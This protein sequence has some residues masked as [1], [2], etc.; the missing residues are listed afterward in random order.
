[1]EPTNKAPY[2]PRFEFG[3]DTDPSDTLTGKLADLLDELNFERDSN[4]SGKRL[5]QTDPDGD[6]LNTK[7]LQRTLKFVRQ[8]TG[9]SFSGTKKALPLSTLKTIKLLYNSN[10]SSDRHLFNF[11][12]PPKNGR[13][14]MEFSTGS[15]IA[16]DKTGAAIIRSLSDRLAREIDQQKIESFNALFPNAEDLQRHIEKV[17]DVDCCRFR[18]HHPKLIASVARTAWG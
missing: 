3:I 5:K 15:S 13:P 18:G 6:A 10:E 11:L 16:R 2:R 9:R 7:S 14:T 1:M 4:V 17:D 12:A 8:V